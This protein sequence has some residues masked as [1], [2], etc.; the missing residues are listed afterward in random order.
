[1]LH[2]GVVGALLVV[3]GALAV[4]LAAPQTGPNQGP[5]CSAR[6]QVRNER[7]VRGP[8]AT[9]HA[10]QMLKLSTGK[11]LQRAFAKLKRERG[12]TIDLDAAW[13]FVGRVSPAPA[14]IP[15]SLHPSVAQPHVILAAGRS[16]WSMSDDNVELLFIPAVSE[17]SYWLGTFVATHFDDVGQADCQEIFNLEL[18]YN[19]PTEAGWA[20]TYEDPIY[21]GDPQTEPPSTI[22]TLGAVPSP[23]VRHTALSARRTVPTQIRSVGLRWLGRAAGWLACGSTWCAGAA[24]GCALA[25]VWNAE[26]AWAPCTGAGCVGGFVGCTYGTLWEWQ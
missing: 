15:A 11:Y 6:A 14:V 22:M 17:E 21:M 13:G 24:A 10:K 18:Q 8:R 4:P 2:R 16:Q 20:A 7:S 12:V 19:Q 5:T 25:H 1:M 9:A 23:A 3:A 26:M